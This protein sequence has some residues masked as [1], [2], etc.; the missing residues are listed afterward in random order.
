MRTCTLH[1]HAKTMEQANLRAEHYFL[2]Q[3]EKAAK[4][5]LSRSRTSGQRKL[6]T[7]RVLSMADNR[8]STIDVCTRLYRA[9]GRLGRAAQ[10]HLPTAVR[11]ALYRSAPDADM[12][13]GE[14]VPTGGFLLFQV[15]WERAPGGPCLHMPESGLELKEIKY[16]FRCMHAGIM[17]CQVHV[18]RW[19]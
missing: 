6:R 8:K 4:I 3:R 12:P 10:A 11:T 18:P 16:P 9:T 17:G 2:W 19:T 5:V 13:K 7:D 14:K 1:A 15:F